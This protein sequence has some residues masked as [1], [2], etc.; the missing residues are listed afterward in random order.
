MASLAS[1]GVH[2]TP[3]VGEIELDLNALDQSLRHQ[4]AAARIRIDL[5]VIPDHHGEAASLA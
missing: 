4:E 5:T 1:R 2:W 3:A